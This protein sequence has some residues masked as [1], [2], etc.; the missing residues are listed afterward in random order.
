MT[1]LSK[2]ELIDLGAA[3]LWGKTSH[4]ARVLAEIV[5]NAV[6]ERLIEENMLEAISEN[7]N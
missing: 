7:K 1:E 6:L 2:T 4:D 3:R 5:V